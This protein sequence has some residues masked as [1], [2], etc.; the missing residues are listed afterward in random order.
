MAEHIV[1]V[2]VHLY[3]VW[4]MAAKI[5]LL[6]FSRWIFFFLLFSFSFLIIFSLFVRFVFLFVQGFSSLFNFSFWFDR[7]TINTSLF[8]CFSLFDV[9]FVYIFFVTFSVYFEYRLHELTTKKVL[10]WLTCWFNRIPQKLTPTKKKTT[11]LFLK[12]EQLLFDLICFSI[13]VLFLLIR[14]ENEWN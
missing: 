8:N 3:T 5:N 12:D 7:L 2:V 10:F 11:S 14:L 6:I 9:F 1:V 4:M 13:V